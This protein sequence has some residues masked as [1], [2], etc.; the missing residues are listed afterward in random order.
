MSNPSPTGRRRDVGGDTFV[1]F[2][3]T[4][5]APIEDVW[6][7]VTESDRLA[8][9]IGSWTGDPAAGE[10]LFHM[11]FEGDDVPDELF[12][13]DECEAPHRLRITTTIPF[14]GK[15]SESW[16]LRL[17]LAEAGGV[18]TLTFAQ[19]VRDPQMVPSVGPGWDYYLDRMVA[20]ESGGDLSAVDFDDYYPALSEHYRQEFGV[21]AA[22][23]A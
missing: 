13:I 7:A 16:Q 1:E 11:D 14:D 9:W 19:D 6:A 2:I 12:R 17:D 8:R 3:R 5:R 10:V 20:A 18:T 15:P 4:F 21:P 22:T 23:Q